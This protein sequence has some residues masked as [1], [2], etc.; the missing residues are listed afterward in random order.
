MYSHMYCFLHQHIC[1]IVDELLSTNM[2]EFFMNTK[3][4][5]TLKNP[6]YGKKLNPNQG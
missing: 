3:Y 2:Y 1:K 4:L 6:R 5:C